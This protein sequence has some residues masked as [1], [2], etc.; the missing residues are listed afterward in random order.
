M[1]LTAQNTCGVRKVTEKRNDKHDTVPEI[2]MQGTDETAFPDPFYPGYRGYPY[3][4]IPG[5]PLTD[6]FTADGD[7]RNERPEYR[8]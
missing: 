8:L 4:V 6:D 3:P 2:Y 1:I 5:E 7:E